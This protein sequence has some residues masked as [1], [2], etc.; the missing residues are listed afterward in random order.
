MKERNES[1]DCLKGIAI[2]LVMFGHVQVHNQMTVPYLYDV[3][4]S[5]QMPLF[6]LIMYAVFVF[7]FTCADPMIGWIER[8][9]G[10]LGDAVGGAW[11]ETTLPFLRSLLISGVIDGVGGVI[12]FL[13]NILFLFLA[14]WLLRGF[15]VSCETGTVSETHILR[16][17]TT[18]T[19]LDMLSFLE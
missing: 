10:A 5:L 6:F 12:V 13:P 18:H 14:L 2:L 16:F 17:F 19:P 8:G 4:K 9:F 7:T 11:P 1:L 15:G 3:I